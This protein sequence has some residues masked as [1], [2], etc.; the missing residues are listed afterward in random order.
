MKNKPRDL[1]IDRTVNVQTLSKESSTSNLLR[2]KQI[3]WV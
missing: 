1:L 3:S 2:H